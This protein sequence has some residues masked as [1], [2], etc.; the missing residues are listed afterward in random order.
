MISSIS[1]GSHVAIAMY[2][3]PIARYAG[4]EFYLAVQTLAPDSLYAGG[5]IFNIIVDNWRKPNT[6]TPAILLI[7]LT[8]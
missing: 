8:S 6:E 1:S 5:G 7:M 4:S 3:I 2:S